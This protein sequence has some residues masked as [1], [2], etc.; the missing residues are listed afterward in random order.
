M[1]NKKGFE[2]LEAEKKQ[3]VAKLTEELEREKK[4]KADGKLPVVVLL[5]IASP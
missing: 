4:R 2:L 1:Q 3:V 5:I